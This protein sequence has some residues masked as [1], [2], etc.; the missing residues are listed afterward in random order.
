MR[1]EHVT[2]CMNWWGDTCSTAQCM[3]KCGRN[4]VWKSVGKEHPM[5]QSLVTV[6]LP[7]P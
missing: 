7:A 5:D 2:A 6:C 1:K 3:E 4:N